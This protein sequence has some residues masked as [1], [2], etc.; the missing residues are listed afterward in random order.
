MILNPPN[1]KAIALYIAAI[2]LQQSTAWNTE[3]YKKGVSLLLQ[4]GRSVC[5]GGKFMRHDN[6]AEYVIFK[7]NIAYQRGIVV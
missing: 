4:K 2:V 1:V 5:D 3:L 7:W 6:T